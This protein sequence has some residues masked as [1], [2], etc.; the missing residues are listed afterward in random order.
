MSAAITWN[1]SL[2]GPKGCRGRARIGD[3]VHPAHR[4][5]RV[6]GAD[7]S[8]RWKC[9]RCSRSRTNRDEHATGVSMKPDLDSRRVVGHD[10]QAQDAS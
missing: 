5:C 2:V 1:Y 9:T 6:Q 7:A 8:P 10:K 4:P 3:I